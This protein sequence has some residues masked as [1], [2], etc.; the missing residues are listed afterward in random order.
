MKRDARGQ[1]LVRDVGWG[2]VQEA[3]GQVF[4]STTLRYCH[5]RGCE[6]HWDE[7]AASGKSFKGWE[8][9]K[10]TPEKPRKRARDANMRGQNRYLY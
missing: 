5:F 10:E 3:A 6:A 2:D 4:R 7:F 8:E 9:A 1:G